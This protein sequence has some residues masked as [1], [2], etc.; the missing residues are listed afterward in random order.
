M[1]SG[2]LDKHFEKQ[3][4][5]KRDPKPLRKN[6]DK[7]VRNLA[8]AICIVLASLSVSSCAMHQVRGTNGSVEMQIILEPAGPP[9]IEGWFMLL[10]FRYFQ[11]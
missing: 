5:L 3:F 1:H 7:F 6:M 2:K 4:T 9:T 8:I 11:P 10:C